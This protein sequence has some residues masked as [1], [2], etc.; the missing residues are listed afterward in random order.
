MLKNKNGCLC[1]FRSNILMNLSY[2]IFIFAIPSF[3]AILS[4]QERL[5]RVLANSNSGNTVESKDVLE[6]GNVLDLFPVDDITKNHDHFEQDSDSSQ[7][8]FWDDI[9]NVWADYF[10][11]PW[12]MLNPADL[13]ELGLFQFT[14]SGRFFDVKSLGPSFAFT[15]PFDENGLFIPS[16]TSLLFL[17]NTSRVAENTRKSMEE[18]VLKDDVSIKSARGDSNAIIQTSLPFGLPKYHYVQHYSL[19]VPKHL[20]KAD[21]QLLPMLS[22]DNWVRQIGLRR[23]AIPLPKDML[24]TNG[25]ILAFVFKSGESLVDFVDRKSPEHANVAKILA[26]EEEIEKRYKSD[27]YTLVSNATDSLKLSRKE[28]HNAKAKLTDSLIKTSSDIAKAVLASSS[29]FFD[30][31]AKRWASTVGVESLQRSTFCQI[32]IHFH[33]QS[34]CLKFDKDGDAVVSL[35]SVPSDKLNS[36]HSDSGL[37]KRDWDAV[38]DY[39]ED[40]KDELFDK[41]SSTSEKLDDFMGGIHDYAYSLGE[42]TED[43]YYSLKWYIMNKLGKFH[44]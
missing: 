4:N 27:N 41:M 43:A 44:F 36:D 13:S 22:G 30:N 29:T 31:F 35:L 25:P 17:F 38:K 24:Q 33:E 42:K 3:S 16:N 9:P 14:Q 18:I 37:S 28:Y 20:V 39:I 12:E 2:L 15:L 11:I 8:S 23:V 1:H 7:V 26:M 10:S 19:L 32:N 34:Y 6:H 40:K 21:L 5:D